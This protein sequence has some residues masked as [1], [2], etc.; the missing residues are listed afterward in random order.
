MARRMVSPSSGLSHGARGPLALMQCRHSRL[1]HV[2]VICTQRVESPTNGARGAEAAGARVTAGVL[3]QP[4]NTPSGR[5]AE[6]IQLGASTISL[7][8]RSTV[9]LHRM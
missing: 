1:H 7:I 8:L 6:T 2:P 9:T 5:N 4:T 3:I